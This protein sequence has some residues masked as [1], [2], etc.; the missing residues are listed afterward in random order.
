M[1]TAGALIASIGASV[2]LVAA[3]TVSLL[4]VSAVFAL[5]GFEGS[6]DAS[7]ADEIVLDLERRSGSPQQ[8]AALSK[9]A[10]VAVVDRRPAPRAARARQPARHRD[11]V[12]SDAV[13]SAASTASAPDETSSAAALGEGT[14]GQA[15]VAEQRPVA[16]AAPSQRAPRLGD[17]VRQLGDGVSASVRQTG[18][19]L[20][21]ATAP[22]GQPVSATV[23]QLLTV[24]AAVIQGTTG[25]LG[26]LLGAQ[27]P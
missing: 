20:A 12:R 8:S 7:S 11:T 18:T 1:R 22:L 14:A 4:T 13:Q 6:R 10:A 26:G 5:G 23:E 16:P 2:M 15:P 19:K 3:V 21:D 25:V 17:G 24:V 27:Q 9:Q